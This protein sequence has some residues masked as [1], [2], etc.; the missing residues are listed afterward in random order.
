MSI[1]PVGMGD[2]GEAACRDGITMGRDAW[3][4]LHLRLAPQEDWMGH[5]YSAHTANQF[6][7]QTSVMQVAG[8]SRVAASNRV[9]VSGDNR[10]QQA[11]Y[12]VQVSP[13]ID[14]HGDIDGLCGCPFLQHQ[15][16]ET[17]W[18]CSSG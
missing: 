17:T 3:V 14:A 9:L 8:R 1:C 4:H 10:K 5:S 11:G 2:L 18:A 6:P 16:E 13:R 15:A 12:L 7:V